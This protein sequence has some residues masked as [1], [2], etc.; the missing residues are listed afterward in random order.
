MYFQ[1][2][3]FRGKLQ[4]ARTLSW[5]PIAWDE[6]RPGVPPHSGWGSCTASARGCEGLLQGGWGEASWAGRWPGPSDVCGCSASHQQRMPCGLKKARPAKG[7]AGDFWGPFRSPGVAARSVQSRFL[8]D[9]G[10]G[11]WKCQFQSSLHEAAFRCS[12]CASPSV[13]L[14]LAAWRRRLCLPVLPPPALL[15]VCPLPLLSLSDLTPSSC[16]SCQAVM[17]AL[18]TACLSFTHPHHLSPLS[19]RMRLFNRRLCAYPLRPPSAR[20][21]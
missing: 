18:P 3:T 5:A 19:P 8:A 2:K 6:A 4:L 16:F 10:L 15:S 17:E 9:A 21:L 7:L 12:S 13:A 14:F 11:F 20:T 1:I